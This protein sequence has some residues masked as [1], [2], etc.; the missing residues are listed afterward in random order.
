MFGASTRHNE[1][2]CPGMN[3]VNFSSINVIKYREYYVN[4]SKY[5]I[6]RIKSRRQ[7]T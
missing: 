6:V 1:E 7:L 4:K 2:F 5:Q 3:P